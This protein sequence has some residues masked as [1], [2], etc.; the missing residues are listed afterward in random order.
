MLNTHQYEVQTSLYI[1]LFPEALRHIAALFHPQNLWETTQ[2]VWIGLRDQGS[3]YWSS[4]YNGGLHTLITHCKTLPV[5]GFP[6]GTVGGREGRSALPGGF[7]P[8]QG[9]GFSQS[10]HPRKHSIP[11]HDMT[12]LWRTENLNKKMKFISLFINWLPE[13][14][15][16]SKDSQKCLCSR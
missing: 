8:S 7:P 1:Y 12:G 16:L 3:Q 5:K 13:M 15:K 2:K 10:T 6:Q 14:Y 4:S 11:R 9:L